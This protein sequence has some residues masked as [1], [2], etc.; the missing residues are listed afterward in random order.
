MD[1]DAIVNLTSKSP[2]Y[3]FDLIRALKDNTPLDFHGHSVPADIQYELS[4][5]DWVTRDKH[6]CIINA[7]VDQMAYRE[8]YLIGCQCHEGGIKHIW[9]PGDP[10]YVCPTSGVTVE[11]PRTIIPAE[12]GD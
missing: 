11:D 5:L 1:K 8:Q 2:D 3:V 10:A 9:Q 6:A 7:D 12:E 4:G